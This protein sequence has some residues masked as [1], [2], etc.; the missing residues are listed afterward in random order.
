M[1]VKKEE[2]VKKKKLIINKKKEEPD[3]LGKA[4]KKSQQPVQFAKKIEGKF[5]FRIPLQAKLIAKEQDYDEKEIFGTYMKIVESFRKGDVEFPVFDCAEW[6]S[7]WITNWVLEKNS[8]DCLFILS[9]NTTISIGQKMYS[10][11]RFERAYDNHNETLKDKNPLSVDE[12]LVKYGLHYKDGTTKQLN[13]GYEP[14]F[15]AEQGFDKIYDRYVLCKK[16]NL[17]LCIPLTIGNRGGHRNMLIINHY[18]NTFERYEPHGSRTGGRE[19][20][21]NEFSSSEEYDDIL[22]KMMNYINK[23]Y[24]EKF[25]YIDPAQTCPR[26]PKGETEDIKITEKTTLKELKKKH[27]LGYT[28]KIKGATR[29]YTKGGDNTHY[30]IT[31][32]KGVYKSY[33]GKKETVEKNVGFQHLDGEEIENAKK[34]IYDNILYKE[35]GGYCC[36]WSFFLMDLRLKNPKINPQELMSKA[37]INLN[38]GE[39]PFRT[40]IRA[41]TDNI[42]NDLEKAF[43]GSKRVLA[44]S[45]RR[46]WLDS[47]GWSDGENADELKKKVSEFMSARLKITTQNLNKK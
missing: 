1:V 28:K 44:S 21:M 16:K 2:P 25:K 42:M 29:F 46:R 18:N 6:V 12:Q 41:Y 30:T 5:D 31:G 7:N 23:E 9:G 8:S 19:L 11:S 17:L 10:P 37:Y 47:G 24:N 3:I 40:F 22:K 39:N 14:E 4:T 13:G 35:V 27:W 15:I 32:W 33:D 36:M 45:V 38:K 20:S 43:G 26:P 34:E